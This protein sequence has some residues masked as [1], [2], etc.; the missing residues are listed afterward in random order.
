MYVSVCVREREDNT[1]IYKH[2]TCTHMLTFTHVPHTHTRNL[3]PD[4]RFAA[5]T[6]VAMVQPTRSAITIC[7]GFIQNASGTA[8]RRPMANRPQYV[9][10]SRAA[11]SFENRSSQYYTTHTG[12][13]THAHRHTHRHTHTHTD[14]QTHT[15]THTHTD[16]HRGA[17]AMND[18]AELR[19]GYAWK[20]LTH[21]S[22]FSPRVTPVHTAPHYSGCVTYGAHVGVNTQGCQ[23][24]AR[25]LLQALT[26]L[27]HVRTRKRT[28][29]STAYVKTKPP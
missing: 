10:V 15:Q 24:P 23:Y 9:D 26:P 22:Y 7:M 28:R 1:C 20:M 16:T 17:R 13:D 8:R 14:T 25:H 29:T 3:T 4:C 27:H 2:K 11:E 12:T 5:M 18:Q 21:I 6:M 19:K